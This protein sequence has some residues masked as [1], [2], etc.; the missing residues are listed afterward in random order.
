V[1]KISGKKIFHNY[2]EAVEKQQKI[3]MKEVFL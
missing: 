2:T 1:T 3:I